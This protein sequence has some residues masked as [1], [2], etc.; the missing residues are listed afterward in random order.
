MLAVRGERRSGAELI[1]YQFRKILDDLLWCQPNSQRFL[2]V[3]H[4]DTQAANTALAF[5][6]ARFDGD[7][8]AII[9]S[10]RFGDRAL[11]AKKA[12]FPIVAPLHDMQRQAC[13]MN[14]GLTWHRRKIA[15]LVKC[16]AGPLYP[17]EQSAGNLDAKGSCHAAEGSAEMRD[18]KT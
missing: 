6:L 1:D 14:A 15:H 9:P 5:T 4:H 13:K 18:G 10:P 3:V 12:G 16:E 17:V 7:S 11:I 8:F 2:N